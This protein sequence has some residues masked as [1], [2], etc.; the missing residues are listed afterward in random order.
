MLRGGWEEAGRRPGGGWELAGKRLGGGWEEAGRRLGGGW[1]EA[2]R[3]LGAGWEQVGRR[4]GASKYAFFRPSGQP[5]SPDF[6][7]DCCH[8]LLLLSIQFVR[9]CM[10]A[11]GVNICIFS[12]QQAAIIGRF[13]G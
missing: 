8:K 13:S 1:E 3:R 11:G 5:S 6:R 10:Q 9:A 2:G 7:G 12:A 4:L